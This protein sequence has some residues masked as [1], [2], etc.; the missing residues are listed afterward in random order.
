MHNREADFPEPK[1]PVGDNVTRGQHKKCEIMM[2][3]VVDKEPQC[4]EHKG[5]PSGYWWASAIL[6]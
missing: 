4:D 1:E 2:K 6:S 3:A 5:E